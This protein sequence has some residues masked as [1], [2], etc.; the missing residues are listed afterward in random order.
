VITHIHSVSIVVGDYDRALQFY[1]DALGFEVTADV[2]DPRSSENRW[3]T[4]K[5]KA[6]QTNIMLLKASSQP[7]ETSSRLGKATSIVLDTDNI[8]AECEHIK[9]RGA[10]ILYPSKRAG[11]GNAL[12]THFADP[13]G[14]TFQ[15]VQRLKGN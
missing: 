13:D 8:Q 11:W 4:L 15:L 3:L 9:S 5:P 6:G 7:P 1:R 10:R 14:N 12:E 2:T